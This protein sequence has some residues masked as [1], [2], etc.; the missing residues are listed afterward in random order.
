MKTIE[1]AIKIIRS[2]GGT[3]R[4]S[5]AIN[6]GIAPKTF[7]SMRDQG[8]LIRL[9]R[10]LYYLAE[11]PNLG[12]PDLLAVSIRYPKVFRILLLIIN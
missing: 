11:A 6:A 8:I 10:G 12:S 5:E 9:S 1:E 7:Y 3:I 4:T 2:N